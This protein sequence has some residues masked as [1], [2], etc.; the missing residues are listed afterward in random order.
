MV[1]VASHWARPASP[2]TPAHTVEFTTGYHTR[3][4]YAVKCCERFRFGG[5][6]PVRA[7]SCP[8]VSVRVPPPLPSMIFSL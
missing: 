6:V 5:S 2:T 8:C 3:N 1:V 4:M 7:R